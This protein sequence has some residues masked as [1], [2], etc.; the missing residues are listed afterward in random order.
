M[1]EKQQIVE[2]FKSLDFDT[3]QNILDDNR[4]YMDV[5]KDLFLST[6]KQ[7]IDEYENLKSDLKFI[8]TEILAIRQKQAKEFLTPKEVCQKLKICTNTLQNY[9]NAGMIKGFDKNKGLG[10]YKKILF[11]NA[12]IEYFAQNRKRLEQ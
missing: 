11:R 7:K 9:I 10:T 3:L 8:A 12:D 5:S 4:S 2:A 1:T 6:L